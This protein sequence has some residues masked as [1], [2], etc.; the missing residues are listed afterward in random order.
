MDT[1]T[2]NTLVH[3]DQFLDLVDFKWLMAGL[4]WRVD[5]SRFQRDI[6]YAGQ[7]ALRGLSTDSAVLQ[8]R[9]QALLAL[10]AQ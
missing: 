8:R 9:S 7:C 3:D 5:L 2:A 1:T 10:L 4:G 6:S